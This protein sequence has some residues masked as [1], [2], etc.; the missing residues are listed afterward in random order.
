M[1]DKTFRPWN[2][3]KS[4]DDIFAETVNSDRCQIRQ[5]ALDNCFL[6]RHPNRNTADYVMNAFLARLI[7]GDHLRKTR[8]HTISGDLLDWK[9]FL[10]LPGSLWS[11]LLLKVFGHHQRKPWLGYRAVKHLKNLIAPHWRVLEFGSGMSTLFFARHCGY[12]ISVESSPV[13]FEQTRALLAK[14]QVRNTDYRF[15]EVK[16]YLSHPDIE[17]HSLDLVVID[18]MVR[19]RCASFALKKVRP[20]GWIFYDN[21]DVPW[22]EYRSTRLQLLEAAKPGTLLLFKDFYPFQISVMESMLIQLPT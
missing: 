21:S 14:Q 19:D 7:A 13:W 3:T 8:L 11:T 15:R 22:P 5:C 1:R 17:D 9:G 10:Y 6:Q 20:G 18:G 2:L 12:L 4:L 16:D